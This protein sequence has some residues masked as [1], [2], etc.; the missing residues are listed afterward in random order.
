[1]LFVSKNLILLILF[2]RLSGWRDLNLYWSKL[3]S[4]NMYIS[5]KFKQ[6]L[7][8]QTER[9]NERYFL[10]VISSFHLLFSPTRRKIYV[11][12]RLF[13]LNVPGYLGVLRK[14]RSLIDTGAWAA[15]I[16]L[17]SKRMLAQK[18]VLVSLSKVFPFCG[19]YT[20]HWP[21]A[22]WEHCFISTQLTHFVVK[23]RNVIS[24]QVISAMKVL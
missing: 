11:I 20:M 9:Q 6:N 1:V 12:F 24:M 4:F 7:L 14:C 5:S 2:W 17:W 23:H 10:Y 8:M 15:G 22:M 13:W 16:G 18:N 21:R 3:T 19:V